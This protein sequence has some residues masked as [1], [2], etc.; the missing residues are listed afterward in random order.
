MSTRPK[1]RDLPDGSAWDVLDPRLGSLELLTPER[2][3]AA[4]RLVRT[5]TRFALDLP[6][7]VPSPPFFGR[8][9][10]RHEVFSLGTDYVFDD[11]L[12]NFFPQ[13]S[14]QWDGFGHFGHPT[15][16]FFGGRTGADIQAKTLGVDAWAETGIAGRGVLLDVARHADIAGDTS[17]AIGPD[18]LTA[19][20]TAQG[21]DLRPGDILCVRV[22]WLAWYRSL[23]AA[24]RESVAAGSRDYRFERFR[25]PGLAPGP[26]IAEYLWD[27]G[28]AAIAL[29]NPGVEPFGSDAIR[30]PDDS[31]HTRVLALLGIPL[32]EFFDLDAVADH[33]AGDRVYEFLFTSKPLGIP[34]GLGSPPNALAIK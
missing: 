20:A 5:G 18:L 9:A 8:D 11:K 12:D 30:T 19:T 25:T 10:Y 32:G 21:V 26:A 22:G 23:D 7:D 27:H 14:T 31:V 16:G 17:F 34:G 24:G 1:Y 2:V 33:C 4:A 13:S 3:A 15:N 6:L 28:V 29:D